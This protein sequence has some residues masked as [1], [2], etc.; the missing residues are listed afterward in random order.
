MF[1]KA[2]IKFFPNLLMKFSQNRLPCI[3]EEKELFVKEKL[4]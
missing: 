1:A 2:N 3:V 4:N